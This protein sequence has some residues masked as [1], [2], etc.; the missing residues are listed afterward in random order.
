MKVKYQ[1][2]HI[3]DLMCVHEIVLLERHKKYFIIIYIIIMGSCIALT[4]VRFDP[5]GAPDYMERE[6]KNGKRK[7]EW[8]ERV[9]GGYRVRN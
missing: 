9:R 1:E 8:Q 3:G 7:E 5:P 4:S 6:K 2:K